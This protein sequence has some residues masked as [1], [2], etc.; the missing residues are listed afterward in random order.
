M[1]LNKIKH[2]M[3]AVPLVLSVTTASK[4]G[5]KPVSSSSSDTLICEYNK[6]FYTELNKITPE[7][8]FGNVSELNQSK[9][10]AT[11]K[12]NMIMDDKFKDQVRLAIESSRSSF[13]NKEKY[14]AYLDSAVMLAMLV[15]Q[16]NMVEFRNEAYHLLEAVGASQYMPKFYDANGELKC[17]KVEI[18]EDSSLIYGFIKSFHDTFITHDDPNLSNHFYRN[19]T[20]KLLNQYPQYK[21][22]TSNDAGFFVTAFVNCN[23]NEVAMDHIYNM[24]NS[25][26]QLLSSCNQEAIK[27]GGNSVY[28]PS[29]KRLNKAIQKYNEY[30]SSLIELIYF[31]GDNKKFQGKDNFPKFLHSIFFGS[32]DQ[33][34]VKSKN[35]FIAAAAQKPNFTKSELVINL[36]TDNMKE[37]LDWNI[38]SNLENFIAVRLANLGIIDDKHLNTLYEI[39]YNIASAKGKIIVLDMYEMSKDPQDMASVTNRLSDEYYAFEKTMSKGD[40]NKRFTRNGTSTIIFVLERPDLLSQVKKVPVGKDKKGN[41]ITQNTQTMMLTNFPGETNLVDI[42]CLGNNHKD[43]SL[44]GTNNNLSDKVY[45]GSK[46]QGFVPNT[47][48]LSNSL[49]D[50][51]IRMTHRNFQ[52]LLLNL[53]NTNIR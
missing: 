41:M 24:Y 21:D 4:L 35:E 32:Y 29:I 52:D 13:L 47:D 40:I 38:S 28:N 19:I 25:E 42:S 5:T 34:I 10:G 43:P 36:S 1:K 12:F 33:K 44:S 20:N 9:R 23:G 27:I 53:V 49:Y 50:G 18:S 7:S 30:N 26:V 37:V 3:L 46:V 8:F 15:A 17:V 51:M 11:C 45:K 22:Y 6:S 16:Y 48:Q 31:A 39:I 14:A 2:L